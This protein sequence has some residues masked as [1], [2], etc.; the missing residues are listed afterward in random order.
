MK[1]CSVFA[2]VWLHIAEPLV[3][4]IDN[5]P[6]HYWWIANFADAGV[7]WCI[8]VFVMISGYLLFDCLKNQSVL[9]FYKRRVKKILIAFLF[10]S[11]LY[12]WLRFLFVDTIGFKEAVHRILTGKAHSHLWYLYMLLGLYLV[13]P[14]LNIF[15][16]RASKR[17]VSFAI[18]LLI[19]GA[20]GYS[21]VRFF[22][23]D[24]TPFILNSC[25]VPYIGFYLCG[26]KFRHIEVPKIKNSVLVAI[27]AINGAVKMYH[28]AEQKYT[29]GYLYSRDRLGCQYSILFCCLLLPG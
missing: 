1:F 14:V 20:S 13:T 6:R 18:V 5:L 17:V 19:I 2:V 29:T 25:F 7:R 28:M 12:L 24:K 21:F 3:R 26:Y 9:H 23:Y 27:I 10:W 11:V 8:P 16:R 22:C 4:N 15:L